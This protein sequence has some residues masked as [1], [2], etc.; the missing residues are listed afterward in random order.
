MVAQCQKLRL[1]AFIT[2]CTIGYYFRNLDAISLGTES[3]GCLERISPKGCPHGQAGG[4]TPGRSE[5]L[6]GVSRNSPRESR[7]KS[8]K[9]ELPIHC[10]PDGT[11]GEYWLGLVEVLSLNLGPCL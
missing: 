1:S 3:G 2:F 8:R 4:Y 7:E 11:A 6:G 10:T 5:K 9:A